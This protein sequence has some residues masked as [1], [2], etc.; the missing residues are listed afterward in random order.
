MESSSGNRD[1]E[2]GNAPTT[3]N[4]LYICSGNTCRSPLA[5]A[6]TEKLLQGRGWSHVRVESAGT[7]AVD[8]A[9]AAEAAVTVAAE[10]SLDLTNHKSREL[11]PELLDWADLVLVMTP[12]Q[13]EAIAQRGAADKVAIV[14]DF[15]E[16]PGAGEAVHDPFGG[17]VAVYRETFEQLRQAA[18]GLLARLEPI[19]AP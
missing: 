10:E 17:D 4:L 8:G 12:S 14:T 2:T 5:K 7:A 13:F 6:I 16:G 1:Y 11:T 19:L 3:Y 18:Q 15:M 9:P